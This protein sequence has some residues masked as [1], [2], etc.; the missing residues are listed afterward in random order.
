MEDTQRTPHDPNT[1]INGVGGRRLSSTPSNIDE[2]TRQSSSTVSAIAKPRKGKGDG[3]GDTSHWVPVKAG[4]IRWPMLAAACL[5]MFGNYFAFDN[6]AV[7]NKPLQEYMQMTDDQF[8]YFLNLLYTS[9]STPNV[10]LPWPGGYASDRFGH[11]KLL[12]VLSIL[13][14]PG[15]LAL[16]LGL[17]RRSIAVMTLGRVVFGS[18][19]S[20]S[21]AQSAITVKYFRGKELA[22]A[23]G[24]NLCMS[25]MSGVLNDMVTPLIW[26]KTSVP[27]AFWCGLLFCIF[28]MVTA[29]VL[30]AMDRRFGAHIGGDHVSLERSR[31]SSCLI[32]A[33]LSLD[34]F[35]HTNMSPKQG[36]HPSVQ[37]IT[38][39]RLNNHHPNGLQCKYQ[40][41]PE[42]E[43]I[44]KRCVRNLR[45][46][47]DYSLS[48]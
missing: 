40:N 47:F 16:C 21:V 17:E 48:F 1:V 22:M 35:A 8:A 42:K 31:S 4:S 18:A 38:M 6:P 43:A 9:Y 23:I 29:F 33:R 15:Q 39:E 13:V 14:V 26:S 32:N 27:F 3:G 34:G 28:S 19:E 5:I 11:N 25:R 7:L 45:P 12:I 37:D 20:L 44:W 10:I 30:V 41:P 46:M 24:I 2:L 36:A